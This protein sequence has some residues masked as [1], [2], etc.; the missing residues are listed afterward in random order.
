MH[1][2]GYGMRYNGSNGIATVTLTQFYELDTHILECVSDNVYEEV[3]EIVDQYMSLQDPATTIDPLN[4]N[5][6]CEMYLRAYVFNN[7][8]VIMEYFMIVCNLLRYSPPS[9]PL[10]QQ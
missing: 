7:R 8:D 9:A 2:R 10:P 3:N 5:E 1:E 6:V 4:L